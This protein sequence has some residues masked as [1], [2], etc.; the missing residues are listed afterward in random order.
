MKITIVSSCYGGY[1]EPR[2]PTPQ[3][4]DGE[5]DVEYVMVTDDATG[6]D[7]WNCI[8]ERRPHVHP[9]VAAKYAKFNPDRYTAA[10]ATV[11]VDAGATLGPGLAQAAA[12]SVLREPEAFHMFPHPHRTSLRPEVEVSRT[13]RKYDAL[14]LEGQIDEYLGQSYPDDRLWATGLIV[15][16]PSSNLLFGDWWMAEV[17]RWGFQDQLSFAFLAWEN[18]LIVEPFGPS[19][20]TSPHIRF[21]DH[22]HKL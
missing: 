2:P 8:V 21:S 10:D 3:E 11:W 7:G 22:T 9:N 19:L 13:L 20:F 4:T 15:R 12:A 6:W 14:D 1:D 16:G 18:S 17:V 5:H